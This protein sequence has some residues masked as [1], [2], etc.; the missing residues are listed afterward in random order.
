MTMTRR[1]HFRAA[2]LLAQMMSANN[3]PGGEPT[4]LSAV[5]SPLPL[6]CN[7]VLV[8]SS[9]GIA[10]PTATSVIS[11]H[12]CSLVIIPLLQTVAIIV[13][14]LLLLPER[15]PILDRDSC[16]RRATYDN[17]NGQALIDVQGL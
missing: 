9:F 13:L 7:D 11:G 8:Q 10:P 12:C 3:G 15:M 16:P 17:D 4:R 1:Q 14:V 5:P 6:D 2:S